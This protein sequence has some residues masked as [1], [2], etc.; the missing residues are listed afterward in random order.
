[1]RYGC[2]ICKSKQVKLIDRA[3]IDGETLQNIADRYGF[4]IS[5]I[6]RHKAH[7]ADKISKAA[8]I[9]DAQEGASILQ[10]LEAILQKTNELLEQ[11]ELNGDIKT[12]LTAIREA[13]GCL[14]L[15]GKATGQFTPEAM[16][17]NF[18]P[19]LNTLVI[20][21]KEEIDDDYTLDKVVKRL[22]A[23]ET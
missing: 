10:R 5:T 21:L 8:A 12:A 6:S 14:E 17:I 7:V 9:Y 20:I 3:I 4:H 13:R 1:M 19:I 22:K 23:I 18:Q 11:A 2:K 15:I 16:L